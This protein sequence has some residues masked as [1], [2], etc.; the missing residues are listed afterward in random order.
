[1]FSLISCFLAL[2][3][4]GAILFREWW[5]SY[6]FSQKKNKLFKEIAYHISLEEWELAE[7]TILV[8]LTKKNYRYQVLLSYARVLK[9]TDRVEE[10]LIVIEEGLLNQKEEKHLF[11]LEKAHC[12]EALKQY[13][14][15]VPLFY[16]SQDNFLDTKDYVAFSRSLLM[17][18]KPKEAKQVLECVKEKLVSFDQKLL[19]GEICFVLKDYKNTLFWLKEAL[20]LSSAFSVDL[21]K[22]IGHTY[23]KLQLYEEAKQCFQALIEQDPYDFEA[24]F[25]LGLCEEEQKNYKKALLIYQTS[26]L[27]GKRD[28]LLMRHGG[29]CAFFEKNYLLAKKC[30]QQLLRQDKA[31]FQSSFIWVKYA[32]CL[33]ALR[34]WRKAEEIYIFI[35]KKFPYCIEGYKALSWMYGVGL[36]TDITLQVGLLYA[37]HSVQ[38]QK[39]Q[40]SLEILSACEAR[41]GNF[42]KAYEIQSLLIS[43][44]NS[45]EEQKRRQRVLRNLRQNLPLDNEHLNRAYIYLAA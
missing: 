12:F 27:W 18:F 21:N 4:L 34:D 33:E 15:A 9:E 16:K 38:L 29:E 37:K 26:Y 44:D 3:L 5:S 40:M 28:P 22:K 1:M 8:L 45:K 20:E 42:K 25:A 10:A 30:F 6:W 14:K 2:V 7:K 19:M 41:A 31:A 39:D 23:R 13:D 24:L 32:F 11:Y 17:L 35:T 36:S 43:Y